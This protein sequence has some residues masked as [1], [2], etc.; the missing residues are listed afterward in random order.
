LRAVSFVQRLL[1]EGAVA[2][3]AMKKIHVHMIAD[4][5]L[6]EQLSVATKSVPV[7]QVL[8]QLRKAGERACDNF[9]SQHG[10]RIGREGSVDLVEMF[11]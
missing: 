4:D 2:S 3:D 7:P 6:M 10:D 8:H 9:L 1:A 11:S 5:A